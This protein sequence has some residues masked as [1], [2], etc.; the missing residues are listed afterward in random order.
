MEI[1]G[2]APCRQVGEIKNAIREAILDG[3]IENNYEAAYGL[4][5]K[6][7]ADLDLQPVK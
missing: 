5:M 2:L 4:M 7:A 3:Q 1:F 6:K